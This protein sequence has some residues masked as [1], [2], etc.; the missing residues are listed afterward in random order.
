MAIEATKIEIGAIVHRA[1]ER[2]RERHALREATRHARTRSSHVAALERAELLLRQ[3]EDN[4]A[5]PF[6][7]NMQEK[8]VDVARRRLQTFDESPA[9]SPWADLECIDV[10]VGV[11]QVGDI[12]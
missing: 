3:Y 1:N 4:A 10:A 6:V 2:D 12:R 11:L 8:K 9:T 5:R 7:R